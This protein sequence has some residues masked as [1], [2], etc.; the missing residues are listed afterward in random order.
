MNHKITSALFIAGLASTPG[1]AQQAQDH[2]GHHPAP[3]VEANA[4]SLTDGEVRRIDKEANKITLRHGA[5][6]NLDMP[7]MT[8]IFQVTDA[9]LLERVKVGDKVRFTA[10]KREGAFMVTRIESA[11]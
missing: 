6:A 7:P 2:A 5:I 1:F 11:S 3:V 9:A 10:E 4:S 8:M